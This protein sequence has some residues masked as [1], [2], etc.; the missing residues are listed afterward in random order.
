MKKRRL[1]SSD[2]EVTAISLGSWL[3][4]SG[5]IEREQTEACTPRRSTRGSTSSTPPT[6][7]ATGSRAR[8]GRDPLRLPARGYI[9]ATK[10][11]LPGR[12]P[13]AG[14]P[15]SR[16]TS[17]STPRWSA[18]GPTTSISTSATASTSRRRSRRR[19]GRSRRRRGR[20]GPPH[21]LQRVDAG[22]DRGRLEPPRRRHVR[23]LPAAVLDALAGARGRGLPLC[24][25]RASPR[26]SGRRSPR[27]C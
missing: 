9:L 17:R 5:G 14:S 18:C 4:Y 6:S 10:V 15:P 12:P 20:Q 16:S 23:L 2:L 19:W 26:S 1:G 24:A 3:T 21:R 27:G 7:T 11:L 25:S 13:T 22:A 8:V